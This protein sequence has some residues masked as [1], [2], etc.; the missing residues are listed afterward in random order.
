MILALRVC[1]HA[2]EI[3]DCVCSADSFFADCLFLNIWIPHWSSL[4]SNPL[5]PTMVYLYGGDLTD[6]FSNNYPGDE[7]ASDTGTIF[8]SVNY[9]VNYFGFLATKEISQSSGGCSGNYGFSDQQSA[10]RFLH[11]NAKTLRVDST[12]I[13]LVGQSSGGTSI[14]ALM[15]SPLS[16]GLFSSAIS[17][18][19]SANMSF[20]LS[21]AEEQN[22]HVVEQLGCAHLDGASQRLSCMRHA[23]THDIQKLIPGSWDSLKLIWGLP[24]P[25][26]AKLGLDGIAIVDG[27]I[28]TLP[29]LEA[30]QNRTIDVPLILGSMAQE[31][32]AQPDRIVSNYTASQWSALLQQVFTPWGGQV[33]HKVQTLYAAETAASFSNAYSTMI[34]DYGAFCANAA[35]AAAAAR[36]LR[37]PV[38]HYVIDQPPS[39]PVWNFDPRAPN[40]LSFHSW[41]ILSG[42]RNYGIFSEPLGLPLYQPSA[43]D[44]QLGAI[45]RSGWQQLITRGHL[46]S[47]LPGG[48][49]SVPPSAAGGAKVPPSGYVTGVIRANGTQ[50]VLG[51][52]Q[53]VCAFWFN[54]GLS[55]GYWWAN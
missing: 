35:V 43:R 26:A 51:H 23:S 21:Q 37:S 14:F 12:R 42:F 50:S 38:Y 41:D 10:L 1:E 20:T 54:L 9:R 11:R 13:S 6:G 28:V 2:A 47:S 29:L 16:L 36:S 24:P 31:P 17:L 27:C 22:A 7:F 19:G 32:D 46:D 52:R 49:A 55:Q 4:E 33:P 5:M 34:A 8:V 15:S 39:S 45:I 30:L 18:S 53:E 3:S 48:W 25:P 44:L 40:T